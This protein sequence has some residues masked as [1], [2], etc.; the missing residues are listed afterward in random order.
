MPED[1]YAALGHWGQRIIV[2]PSED[3]V[4]VRTGDDRKGSIEV[5][6]LT[7]LSLAVAR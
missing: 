1:A 4:I 2:V 7:K 3:V 5:N 6:E